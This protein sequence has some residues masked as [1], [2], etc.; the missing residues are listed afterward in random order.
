MSKYEHVLWHL[1]LPPDIQA[2]E[3]TLGVHHALLHCQ[4]P[5]SLPS[6]KTGT[7]PY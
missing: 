5:N 6:S 4:S 7:K 3:H 1:Q 2:S